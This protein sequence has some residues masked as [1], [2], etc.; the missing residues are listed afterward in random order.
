MGPALSGC[1][2]Y[3]L[4]N[5]LSCKEKDVQG[6]VGSQKGGDDTEDVGAPTPLLLGAPFPGKGAGN[7][8]RLLL[9]GRHTPI[10]SSPDRLAYS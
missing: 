6:P 10:Y 3:Y 8:S 7:L 9:E 5:S 1:R 2:T 4:W